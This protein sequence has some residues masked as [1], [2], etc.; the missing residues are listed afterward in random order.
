[1]NKKG[2]MQQIGP[3]ILVFVA[4]IVAISLFNGGITSNVASIRTTYNAVNYTVAAPAVNSSVSI[5]GKEIVGTI[6]ITNATGNPTQGLGRNGTN[7]GSGNFTQ[8]NN[9]IVNGVLTVTLTT[10]DAGVVYANSNVNLS[11]NYQP[12]TYAGDAG[13]RGMADLI[14]IFSALAIGMIAIGIIIQKGGILELLNR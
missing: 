9:Q 12:V 6:T 7:V 5:P 13:S 11:Y 4:I 14:I 8:Q 2:Q 10:P 3:I 1:M